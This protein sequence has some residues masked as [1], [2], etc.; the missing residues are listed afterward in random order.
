M[1]R[2]HGGRDGLRVL[3]WQRPFFGP[4]ELDRISLLE[5]LKL[6]VTVSSPGMNTLRSLLAIGWFAEQARHR[7]PAGKEWFARE[8]ARTATAL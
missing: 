4:L 1:A 6:P 8:I 5:S 2:G 7:F 3:D